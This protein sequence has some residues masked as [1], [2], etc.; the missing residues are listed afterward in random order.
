MVLPIPF[1]TSHKKM[2]SNTRTLIEDGLVARRPTRFQKLTT[3]LHT[4]VDNDG[5]FDKNSTSYDDIFNAFR[6]NLQLYEFT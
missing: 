4:A 2:L 6:L 3:S 5:K 1:S